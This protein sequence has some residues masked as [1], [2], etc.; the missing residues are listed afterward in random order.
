MSEDKACRHIHTRSG[1]DR[2]ELDEDTGIL[3]EVYLVYCE[4][5]G[6][7]WEVWQEV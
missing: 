7:S 4:D 6:A 5:C 1:F 3:Y 2:Y